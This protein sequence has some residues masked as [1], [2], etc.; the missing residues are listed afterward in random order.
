MEL[1]VIEREERDTVVLL[2]K[3]MRIVKPVYNYLKFQRQKDKA[4]NT[5][6]ANGNDLK[7]FWEFLVE[8]GYEYDKV[9]PSMIADFI[10]FL[11]KGDEDVLALHKESARTN[12]TIN[13][14][15]ST[16][17]MFYQYEADMQ[18]IDNPMLMH[19][20]TRPFN[21]FK[22][23][24]HH[25]KSDNKTKQSIFK[26]KESNHVVRLVVDAEVEL[27][28]GQMTK[29]RDIL[30]YKTLYLTGARIQEVLDLTIESVPVPDMSKPV[31]IFQQIKSK[32]KTRDLY[33]PMSLIAELD[34]FIFEERNLIDTDNS[35]IFVS[36]QPK[37]SGKQLTYSAVYDK[38]KKVQNEIGI[39]F[40][41]HDFRHTF[42]S[43][44]IQSGM[45]V[46]V[47]RI[48]MGHE[49]ISTTQKYT[50]LSDPY[51]EDSLSRYWNQSL[52]IGGGSNEK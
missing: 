16:V 42:C 40:N 19:E 7:L 1:H 39:Y 17:H 51:I 13:R 46:S 6:K 11:R 14:I 45:D 33:V 49:H 18:E 47:A 48:I 21:M 30:L 50:H 32:G 23:I 31:G 4:I 52:L 3:E 28:L 27:F 29:R 26:V 2:D 37:Q 25:A 36:E 38:L 5:I 43:N 44:L 41:F 24:L 8:N 34:D 22:S 15:L 35:Y 20:V 12:R 10:D 9:T